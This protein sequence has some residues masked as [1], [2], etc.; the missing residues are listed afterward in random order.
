[1][2][3]CLLY[4]LLM[5]LTPSIRPLPVL[6]VC[7]LCLMVCKTPLLTAVLEE[8]MHIVIVVWQKNTAIGRHIRLLVEGRVDHTCLEWEAGIL[9]DNALIVDLACHVLLALAA[10]LRGLLYGSWLEAAYDTLGD[11]DRYGRG[12]GSAG[13]AAVVVVV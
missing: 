3:A 5:C 8:G 11:A 1:M 4:H 12:G 7:R 13:N 6:H 10:R 9:S 2:R